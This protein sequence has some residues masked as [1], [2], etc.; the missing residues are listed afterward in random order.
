MS[1]GQL[2]A[3]ENFEFLLKELKFVM[4]LKIDRAWHT[5]SA[6]LLAQCLIDLLP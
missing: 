2:F 3:W 1:V 4:S 5:L 6:M